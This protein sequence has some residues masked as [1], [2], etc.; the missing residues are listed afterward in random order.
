MYTY[1]YIYIYISY[2]NIYIYI[3]INIYIYIYE[4]TWFHGQSIGS[5]GHAMPP[6]FDFFINK[7][8]ATTVIVKTLDVSIFHIYFV[9]LKEKTL[10][11]QRHTFKF[12]TL[13][14]QQRR[15]LNVIELFLERSPVKLQLMAAKNGK[16]GYGN[17]C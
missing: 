1:I 17:G 5:L 11:Y 10:N 3:N 16:K 9:S 4:C 2:I 8:I 13:P 7:L 15:L 14:C 12:F 6:I